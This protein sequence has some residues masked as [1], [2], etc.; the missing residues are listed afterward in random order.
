ML[1]VFDGNAKQTAKEVLRIL[2]TLQSKTQDN[3][4][5]FEENT[6]RNI[7]EMLRVLKGNTRQNTREVLM[8]LRETQSKIQRGF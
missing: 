3:C 2:R 7:N 5:G 6:T 1:T 8:I 4:Q